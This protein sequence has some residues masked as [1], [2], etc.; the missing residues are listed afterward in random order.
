MVKSEG[1]AMDETT[2]KP[3]FDDFESQGEPSVRIQVDLGSWEAFEKPRHAVAKEWLR[4]KDEERAAAS[5]EKRDAR[6][7]ETLAIARR[8]LANSARANTIAAIAIICSVIT[9]IVAAI[10]AR[11]LVWEPTGGAIQPRPS[12]PVPSTGNSRVQQS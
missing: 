6:E 12:Q 7:E 5:S 3:Y 2:R 8:A 9:A 1:E 4:L 10:I 11:S